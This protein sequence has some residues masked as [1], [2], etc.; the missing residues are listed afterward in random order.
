VYAGKADCPPL[1]EGQPREAFFSTFSMPNVPTHPTTIDVELAG[2]EVL[3]F[4]DARIDVIATPGHTPGSGC[5]LLERACQR[6]LFTGD[7]TQSLDRPTPGA[8]GTYT[9]Y[10]P[11]LYR[12]DARDYLAT[13]RRLRDLPTPDLI[14]PGHPRMDR[15]PQNPHLEPDRWLALLDQGIGAM[16]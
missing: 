5:Y 12:G 6:I 8:L 16:E 10:L 1:R 7:V 4:G 11:P 3:E 14:L 2:G 13:L 15:A 9:A